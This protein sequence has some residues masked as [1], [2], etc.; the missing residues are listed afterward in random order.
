MLLWLLLLSP[1]LNMRV[2]VRSYLLKLPVELDILKMAVVVLM[3]NGL[4]KCLCC[5][6]LVC[7][8]RVEWDRC[9]SLPMRLVISLIFNLWLFIWGCFLIRINLSIRVGQRVWVYF[10][11]YRR[12]AWIYRR[13]SKLWVSYVF[14]TDLDFENCSGWKFGK[15]AIYLAMNFFTFIGY[16][17]F[18]FFLFF[19]DLL[20]HPPLR[21]NVQ[22]EANWNS[23][24]IAISNE[25]K[26]LC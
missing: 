15:D 4:G 17:L 20:N 11:C 7:L 19:M 1:I 2:W 13:P 8:R 25:S 3:W 16:L 5:L 10:W 21:K 14:E 9:G 26:C 12:Y 24:T 23:I 18:F 22:L 6:F